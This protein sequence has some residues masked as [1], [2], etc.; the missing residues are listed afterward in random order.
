MTS[1]GRPFGKV[2]R[3]V[4]KGITTLHRT[5][6]DVSGGRLG[7]TVAGNPVSIL[8]TTGRKSG[9]SRDTPLFAYADGDDFIVVA[10][11]GGTAAPPAWF[12]NLQANPEGMIRSGGSTHAI[13]ADVMTPE[14]KATW[15]PELTKRYPS[16]AS[17]QA[18]TDRDIP[19]L[20]LR[21]A[22][23]T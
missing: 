7:A 20:R 10:S 5:A 15:W 1:R 6:F 12:L 4:Q 19:V 18:K 22:D 3:V 21:R 14:E 17:Y 2:Q 8:T 11:N 9:Q 16:Y 23:G 13:R